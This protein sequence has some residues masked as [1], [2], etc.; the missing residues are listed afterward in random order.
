MLSKALDYFV[1]YKGD[2][3]EALQNFSQKWNDGKVISETM[4]T[5]VL[6]PLA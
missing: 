5:Y 1:V 2:A 6:E 4:K 3:S